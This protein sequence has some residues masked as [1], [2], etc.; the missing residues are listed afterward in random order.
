MEDFAGQP[1]KQKEPAGKSREHHEHQGFETVQ[2]SKYPRLAGPLIVH[3]RLPAWIVSIS[4][5]PVAAEMYHRPKRHGNGKCAAR[6]AIQFS[7]KDRR[8]S[9]LGSSRQSPY[10]SHSRYI[11]IIFYI[12]A[13][14]LASNGM[15]IRSAISYNLLNR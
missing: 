1:Q 2:P 8:Y 12:M 15:F 6:E 10:Y 14:I 13:T 7:E 11:R 9:L 4:S 5:H 3:A